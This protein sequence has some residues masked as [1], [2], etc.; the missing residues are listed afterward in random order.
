MPK[1][2][3]H[4]PRA[5]GVEQPL[6]ELDLQMH[7]PFLLPMDF[8]EPALVAALVV[9]TFATAGAHLIFEFMAHFAEHL[10]VTE[11]FFCQPIIAQMMDLQDD[12]IL[13]TALTA[14]IRGANGIGFE[15]F[16]AVGLDVLII[17]FAPGVRR[18]NRAVFPVR[19]GSR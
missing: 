10:D 6:S 14:I 7:I 13:R 8:D 11:G 15:L 4:F 12:P 9:A 1:H 2:E 17:L 19:R 16:P 18:S 5:A 3:S